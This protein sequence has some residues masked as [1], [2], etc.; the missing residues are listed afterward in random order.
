MR[1]LP[2]A[3]LLGYSYSTFSQSSSTVL[4]ARA[5]AL[6]NASACLSDEWSVVN[7]IG[8]LASVTKVTTAFS[9]KAI[10]QFKSFNKMAMVGAIPTKLGVAGFG[11]YRFG[12]D[13]YSEQILSAGFG[14]RF[15]LASLGIKV[16]YIQYNAEGFGRKDVFTIS[17][18]GI[19]E[20]TPQLLVGAYI[21]NINQP[22]LEEGDERVPT[23]LT[24]GIAFKPIN[25][26]FITTEIEKDLDYDATW[27]AGIEYQMHK[28]FLFRTG[29]NINPNAGFVGLGFRPAKFLL[30]YA[31]E[32]ASNIGALHQATVGYQFIKRKNEI[33]ADRH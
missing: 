19:A 32:Y 23:I 4:S 12:D 20:L 11:V 28:K 8:G 27:K 22:K 7:N 15:G 13:L 16:N 18:G 14:N 17:A 5:H 3:I 1:L 10:P 25:K 29:F 21:V 6:G 31:F 33:A 9:F 2:L 24:V 26:V 30:D